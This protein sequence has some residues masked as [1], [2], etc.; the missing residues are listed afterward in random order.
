MAFGDSLQAEDRMRSDLRIRLAARLGLP[1]SVVNWILRLD[2][3]LRPG[4]LG[5]GQ[6][7]RARARSLELAV[8]AETA[9]LALRP[10]PPCGL[11]R[12][13]GRHDRARA[14]TR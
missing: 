8:P 7:Y 6:D 2:S 11:V 10:S 4:R 5:E 3:P 9:S 12:A 14:A 13:S 1:G